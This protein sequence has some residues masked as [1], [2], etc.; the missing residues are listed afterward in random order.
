MTY[1]YRC[2][3]CAYS[4]QWTTESEAEDLAAAHYAHSHPGLT[5]GGG[6]EPNRMSRR[7]LGCLA[8]LGVAL[9]LILVLAL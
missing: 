4:A 8:V 5:P 1:R 2:G 9:L 3:E 7:S 6:T